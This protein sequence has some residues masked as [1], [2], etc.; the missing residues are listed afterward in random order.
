MQKLQAAYSHPLQSSVFTN[1]P[2][3][4]EKLSRSTPIRAVYD[5]EFQKDGALALKTFADICDT[6]RN[7]HIRRW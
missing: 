2:K 3:S 6:D 5:S 1:M 7:S 4:A